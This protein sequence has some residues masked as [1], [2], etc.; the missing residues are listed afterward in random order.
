MTLEEGSHHNR[1]RLIPTDHSTMKKHLS[2]LGSRAPT[3][4]ITPKTSSGSHPEVD[5]LKFRHGPLSQMPMLAFQ[6]FGEDF[7]DFDPEDRA[8]N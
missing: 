2:S 4:E 1:Y 7:D 8:K 5:Q 6:H 3:L